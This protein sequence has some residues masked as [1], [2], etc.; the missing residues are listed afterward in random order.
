MVLEILDIP[1]PEHLSQS[2]LQELEETFNTID[3]QLSCSL[4]T[5]KNNIDAITEEPNT[6]MLYMEYA[7]LVLSILS[8]CIHFTSIYLFRQIGNH[9]QRNS[10]LIN[11]LPCPMSVQAA[12]ARDPPITLKI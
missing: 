3:G 7:S 5:A 9:G 2:V 6:S 11:V 8:C 4:E 1:P 10:T 12:T